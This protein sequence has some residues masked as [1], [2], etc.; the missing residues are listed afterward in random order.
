MGLRFLGGS[1]GKTGSPRIYELGDE[2]I[3]Q[4]YPVDD[5]E[6]LAQMKIPDG[7]IV[8]RVPKSLV[9]YLPKDEPNGAAH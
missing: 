2:Y 6:L 1:T 8:V 7:E 9:N 3:W 4:G 5:P